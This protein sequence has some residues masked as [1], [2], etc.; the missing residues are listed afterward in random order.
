[1]FASYR[2]GLFV[3][4][5][6][7]LFLGMPVAVQSQVKLGYVNSA[8]IMK[9]V[10]DAVEASKKIE[11]LAQKFDKE[12][13]TMNIELENKNKQFEAQ[14]LL[15]SEERKAESLREIQE[16]RQK[17][18]KYQEEKFGPQGELERRTKDL[19]EPIAKK[20]Q[21]VIDKIGQEEGF[22][23]IFDTVNA[24]IVFAR[25]KDTD[26]TERVIAE[27]NKGLSQGSQTGNK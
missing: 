8:L 3:I 20:I 16:L 27:L 10:K 14:Q 24:N 4:L 26:L 23:F 7:F 6:T 12:R 19:T 18:L 25:D 9:Q 1:M 2:I 11:E 22:N 13:Q 15:L 5:I 17:L 21:N